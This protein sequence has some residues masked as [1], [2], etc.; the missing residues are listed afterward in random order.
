M[1]TVN[2]PRCGGKA[3]RIVWGMLPYETH[4]KCEADPEPYED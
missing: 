2:C 3:L 4:K 1:A